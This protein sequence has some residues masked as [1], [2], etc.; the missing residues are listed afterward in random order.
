M[1]KRIFLILICL[2]ITSGLIYFN[3]PIEIRRKS[4]IDFGNRMVKKVLDYQKE[5]KRLP[6]TGDWE[7]LEQLGFKVNML[8]TDPAYER[9]DDSVFE[10]IYLEGFDGPYLLYNSKK[11]KWQLGFPEFPE[12]QQGR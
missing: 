6:E 3:L 11:N 4:E 8:G 9:I 1:V 7:T 5:N 2:L 12:R 10:L